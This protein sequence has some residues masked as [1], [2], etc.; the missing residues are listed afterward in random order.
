[1]TNLE[2]RPLL[3][4]SVPRFGIAAMVSA[5]GEILTLRQSI[6]ILPG[7]SVKA[8]FHPLNRD[9]EGEERNQR[10]C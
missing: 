8:G 10:Q 7:T 5:V 9:H 4:F 6:S 1:M 3:G 2:E